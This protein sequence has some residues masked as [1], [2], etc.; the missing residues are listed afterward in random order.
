V[1]S[2]LE[3]AIG[4]IGFFF[5]LAVLVCEKLDN[6]LEQVLAGTPSHFQQSSWD[7]CEK[8]MQGVLMGF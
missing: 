2:F 5:L 3:N 1:S 6:P 4:V 8:V 7:W